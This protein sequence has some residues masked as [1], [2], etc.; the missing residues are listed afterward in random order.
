MTTK[1]SAFAAA[2][3]EASRS[4]TGQFGTQPLSE[5]DID[6]GAPPAV[7]DHAAAAET[8]LR[9]LLDEFAVLP[10]TDGRGKTFEAA[11]LDRYRD[12]AAF[13]SAHPDWERL[14]SEGYQQSLSGLENTDLGRE[15]GTS[16]VDSSLETGGRGLVLG[17]HTRNGSGNRECWHDEED[18]DENGRVPGCTG[19]AMNAIAGHPN[20]LT[21]E[22]DYG[23]HTFTTLYFS[24]PDQDAARTAV[25]ADHH[26]PALMGL[27]RIRAGEQ[28]PWAAGVGKHPQE[29]TDQAP[30]RLAFKSSA[31]AKAMRARAAATAQRTVAA[32]KIE[33][34]LQAD[35]FPTAD[36]LL[37]AAGG[38]G[39]D[40]DRPTE[41]T[42]A[43]QTLYNQRGMHRNDVKGLMEYRD[44]LRTSRRTIEEI[45]QV[46]PTL[47]EDSPLR[48]VLDR[49]RRSTASHQPTL[50]N[51]NRQYQERIA[52]RLDPF[53]EFTAAVRA[54]DPEALISKAERLEAEAA[55]QSMLVGWP[56]DPASCPANM[57]RLRR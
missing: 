19:C 4:S 48:T 54:E 44:K 2:A 40:P 17:V 51:L 15:R 55:R 22:E 14:T 9:A 35:E 26:A 28:A 11:F 5:A 43:V 38:A 12:A 56:D 30:G 25:E 23:D 31:E 53:Q 36:A 8:D 7:T 20:Y 33:E 18:E 13:S 10:A 57:E 41:L 50:E 27:Q 42:R 52:K 45:D 21:D 39:Y 16:I 37:A 46:T 32:A 1:I 3:R 24:I 47:A 49:E 29:G 34:A 6:L